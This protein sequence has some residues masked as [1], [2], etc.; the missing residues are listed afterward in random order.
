[1]FPNDQLKPAIRGKVAL[2]A[3]AITGG[4]VAVRAGSKIED[5]GTVRGRVGYSWDRFL[6]YATGGFGYGQVNSSASVA[7]PGNAPAFSLSTTHAPTGWTVGGGAEYGITNN[8]TFKTE[9]LY[10]NLG[11]NNVFNGTILGA[12]GINL[13]Q[14]TTANIVRAGL[15]YNFGL[16]SNPVPVIAQY[17]PGNWA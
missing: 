5:F 3:S 14:K 10:V 13:N 6:V 9:Y 2:N 11:T 12:V 7:L 15:N 1:M 16:F 4:S 17:W 8:L